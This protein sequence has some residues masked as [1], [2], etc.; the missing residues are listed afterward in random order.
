MNDLAA[1]QQTLA[2]Q[3]QRERRRGHWLL[4]LTLVLCITLVLDIATGP[5]L[6]PLGEVVD[7]LLAPA[8]ADPMTRTIVHDMRLPIALMALVV[9]AA[10]G[11]GG[12]QMQ[13]LLD[14]PLAS[15][16]TL[17]LA[18]AAGLGAALRSIPAVLDS[19]PL[20]PFRLAPSSSACLPRAFYLAW[21]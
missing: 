21:P 7:A 20:W 2:R 9:G 6:L 15:P 4:L 19:L 5:S 11:L 13:T 16:Y 12:V 10:L 8:Q 17:G 1:L 3:W 18:A 14:N